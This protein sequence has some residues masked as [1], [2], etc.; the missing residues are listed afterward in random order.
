LSGA[1]IGQSLLGTILD[2]S[3]IPNP[4]CLRTF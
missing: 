1:I 3:P 2:R 4:V